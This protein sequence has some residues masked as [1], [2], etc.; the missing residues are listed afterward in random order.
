MLLLLGYMVKAA[1]SATGGKEEEE[2]VLGR[3]ASW[4]LCVEIGCI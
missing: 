2:T 3:V 4:T 1:D